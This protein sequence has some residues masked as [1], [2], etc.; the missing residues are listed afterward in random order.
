MR[1]PLIP[2]LLVAVLT[3]CTL[4]PATGAP[5][6]PTG[7]LA[8]VN[9]HVVPVDRAPFNGTV[10]VEAGKITRL[11]PGVTVPGGVPVV[12]AKGGWLVPGFVD[13]HSHMGV[14]P[15]PGVEA[16]SDG[17]EASD[18]ITPQVRTI[19]AIH[20]EDPAFG[21]ALSGGV[22]SAFIIPGS[23]NL[24]GGQGSV[25]KL[26]PGASVEER[27]VLSPAG[28]KMALGENPK[29]TYGGR[30]Q[31]PATRM[32]V[33][34]GLRQAFTDGQNYQAKWDKYTRD[35]AEYERKHA[36]W[37]A[38]ADRDPD[39]EPKAPDLPDKD[40]K[41]EAIKAVLE[42]RI[43]AHIHCHRADDML[44][45][46]RLRD[47]FGFDLAALHHATEGYLILDQ[48]KDAQVPV[49][50]FATYWAGAKIELDNMTPR[51]PGLCH[52]AGLT[53][54]LHTD[55][56][57]VNQE[58]FRDEAALAMASGMPHDA[59]L[60]AMTLT[61]AEILRIDDRVGSITAGK[62]A[63]LV[64]FSGDPLDIQQRAMFV[65][66]DG[67]LVYDRAHGGVIGAPNPP[68]GGMPW[69]GDRPW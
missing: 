53:V 32:G 51:N 36:E 8:I 7:T 16:N 50:Q 47:E 60:R 15:F 42:R 49:V 55:H 61:P 4:A 48:L 66:I 9:A 67:K 59:A 69:F 33:A 46:I 17:N 22:T 37:E 19:D 39:K 11:G 40:L 68:E 1:C 64:L 13:P 2:A 12:D 10:L 54:A 20:L 45:A 65:W 29:R 43:P 24:I 23:A 31:L 18:P 34:A 25:I 5:P 56:P 52:A 62:D 41:L 3:C 44:T 28:M 63:D 21:L 6:S 57:V 14:Y 35:Q 27:V 38:Q 30:G 26:I 58:Y